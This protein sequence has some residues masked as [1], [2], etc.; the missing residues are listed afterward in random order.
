MK[1]GRKSVLL[2]REDILNDL[3]PL[4]IDMVKDNVE[5]Y[6]KNGTDGMV[7][8]FRGMSGWNM[9]ALI[10][11]WCDRV[12]DKFFDDHPEVDDILVKSDSKN[13]KEWIASRDDNEVAKP[14]CKSYVFLDNCCS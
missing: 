8:G 5:D 12:S 1:A 4:V 11:F 13:M 7:E 6:V 3:Y 2:S 14:E 9:S 10:N